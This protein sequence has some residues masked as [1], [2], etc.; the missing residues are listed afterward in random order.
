M[1]LATRA[2]DVIDW[3]PIFMQWVFYVVVRAFV[4]WRPVT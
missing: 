4:V 3:K 2:N 1:C